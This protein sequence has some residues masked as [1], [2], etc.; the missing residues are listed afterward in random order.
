MIRAETPSDVAAIRCV[1][2]AAFRQLQE[3]D[4][5]DAIRDQCYSLISLVAEEDGAILGHVLLSHLD[6]IAAGRSIRAAALGPIAV[7]P[8]HQNQGIGSSLIR[9]VL[10]QAC[11]DG[12]AIVLVLGHPAYYPR[13][14]FCAERARAMSSPYTCHGDAWMVAELIPGTLPQAS[15]TVAYPAPWAMLD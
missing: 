10:D 7:L 5:I 15:S 9:R 1:H 6:V 8:A 2:E 3:A 13:F 14:G 11:S 12:V 4:L